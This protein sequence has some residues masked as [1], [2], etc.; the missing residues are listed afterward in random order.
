M[1]T[2]YTP[3]VPTLG[4]SFLLTDPEE[5]IAYQ[6]RQF[7]TTSKSASNTFSSM[8]ESLADLISRYGSDVNSII[9]PVEKALSNVLTR[10]FSPAASSSVS[11]VANTSFVE[12]PNYTLTITVQVVVNGTPYT[13]SRNLQSTNGAIVILNDSVATPNN[14]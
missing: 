8:T 14:I 2:N 4:A 3:M 9:S 13:V 7:A 10:V 11:V 5:I 12:Y 1:A 6:I